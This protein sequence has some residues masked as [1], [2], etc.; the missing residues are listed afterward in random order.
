MNVIPQAQEL[1][2]V[3]FL[4]YLLKGR[5]RSFNHQTMV[6]QSWTDVVVTSLQ[7]LWVG[8]VSFIPGLIGAIIVLVL[9]LIVAAGLGTLV[10]KIFES[11]RL[12]SFLARLSL[13]PYFDR[14]GLRLR[15]A[16]F[17]G[18][19]V[20]WFIVVAFLLAASDILGLF[21]L[22]SFL[23]E[24]LAYLPNV[25]AAVLILLAAVVVAN[26]LKKVVSASV[27]SARLHAAHFLG[28]LTWWAIV[29]FGLLTALVQLKIAESIIQSIITGFIAMLA[30]AGGLAF[31]LGGR[32]YA[33]DLIK[34][35]REHTG[36]KK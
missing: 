17:L 30:L 4:Q 34:Q 33:A 7:N 2:C 27:L 28:T 14:A 18:R 25:V 1:S 31:G 5:K 6:I 11:V 13:V 21:A 15:G 19:L 20:Y 29:V 32:E 24:V 23:R 12:D 35:L 9:G 3:G 10:E 36:A 16:H 8:F 22:S 26:F